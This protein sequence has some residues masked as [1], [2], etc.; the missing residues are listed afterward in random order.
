M[1][2][3]AH[4]LLALWLAAALSGPA[5]AA[6]APPTAC[7][8]ALER[9]PSALQSKLCHDARP[10]DAA[11]QNLHGVLVLRQGEPLAEHYFSGKDRHLGEWGSHEQNFDAN[12]LHDLRSIS[13]SV[14]GLL[15]GVALQ[16]G[17]IPS[18]DTPV[19]D[20]LGRPEASP[21]WRAI[22]V[23]HLLTMSSGMDWNEDGAVSL[24]SD[25]SRMEFSS[26]MVGYVLGR[27][28]MAPP[29]SQYRYNSGGVV[30]L[31]AVLERVS[32]QTLA[33][34]AQQAL[35]DPLGIEAVVWQT[36]RGQQP[37]PHAGLRLR[38][39]DL[40]RL[41]QMLLDGGRWQG[42]QIVPEA[43][44][45]DSF[46]GRLPAEL[47]GWRYGYLWRLGSHTVDGRD[48]AWIAAMGNGGQRLYLVPALKLVVVI[49]AGRY[50]QAAPQN[51][52]PSQLLFQ[53][54]LEGVAR[55]ASP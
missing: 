47:P 24:F 16:Q 51:G 7:E 2:Q 49:T 6:S 36:G 10:S 17:L 33:K 48:W 52:R 21:D 23:R 42:R 41:G 14:V 40:A 50:N 3:P 46:E 53:T 13:K 54:L 12:T 34:Y 19:L 22:T 44:V 8:Q 18:L 28:L 27:S 37:M 43:H 30:L 4:V 1:R 29:G 31:G 45:R 5:G 11:A 9:P 55:T 20:L 15:V 25:E 32:G 38:P 26:D 39:R 35:F